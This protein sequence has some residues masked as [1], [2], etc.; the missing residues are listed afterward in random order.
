MDLDRV[1][2]LVKLFGAS[3]ARELTVE[4]E[5]WHVSLR[6]EGVP[7]VAPPMNGG[8]GPPSLLL[9]DP[10]PVE[11]E[12]ST[13]TAPL[14]GIFREGNGG[15]AV[16]DLIQAGETVGGIESMKILSPVLCEV[17]GQ[18]LEILIEDGHPVDYGQPLFVLTPLPEPLAEEAEE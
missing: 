13:V 4:A 12:T 16:G 7:A 6:R 9:V 11:P 17:S 5:G 15:V 2:K 10:E 18:V 1:E 3:R 14:V 8:S